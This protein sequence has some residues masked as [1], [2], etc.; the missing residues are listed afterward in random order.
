MTTSGHVIDG[1]ARRALMASLLYYRHATSI[2]PDSE[3]DDLCSRLAFR[4]RAIDPF[5]QWQMGSPHDLGAGGSHFKITKACEGGALSWA[6]KRLLVSLPEVHPDEWNWDT[7]RRVRWV[8][9]G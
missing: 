1:L 7:T 4:W 3:F 5:L 9:V 2:M 6:R 8:T